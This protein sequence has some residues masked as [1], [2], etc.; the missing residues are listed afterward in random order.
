MVKYALVST[1]AVLISPFPQHPGS[2]E[3]RARKCNKVYSTCR[4]EY[5]TPPESDASM[6][7]ACHCS[8]WQLPRPR[9]RERRSKE[10][11]EEDAEL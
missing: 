1:P 10:G 7:S 2:R 5:R 4:G 11:R 3:V 6:W 9:D 8:H